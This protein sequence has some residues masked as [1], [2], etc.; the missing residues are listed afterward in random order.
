MGHGRKL[1]AHHCCRYRGLLHRRCLP[2]RVAITDIEIAPGRRPPPQGDINNLLDSIQEIGLRTP[3]TLRR[4][5]GESAKFI[6]GPGLVRFEAVKCL[7][8]SHVDAFIETSDEVD[9][10][11]WIIDEN[12]SRSEVTVLERARLLAERGELLRQKKAGQLAHPGGHQPADKGISSTARELG[13][14]RRISRHVV[15]TD[16]ELVATT[17]WVAHTHCFDQFRI[18]PRLCLTSPER[19]CG[20]TTLLTY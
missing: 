17:L 16:D 8:W 11:L 13:L 4:L 18:S 20:K 5:P 6:L 3:V 19:N 10:R 7:G 2:H 9:A 14:M 15:V 1:E 12:L